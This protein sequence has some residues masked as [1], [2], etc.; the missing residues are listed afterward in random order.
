MTGGEKGIVSTDAELRVTRLVGFEVVD[1]RDGDRGIALAVI[2]GDGLSVRRSVSVRRSDR[3]H[4]Q[5]GQ[6][7]TVP[8]TVDVYSQ[9]SGTLEGARFPLRRT[10]TR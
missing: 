6:S 9:P 4:R 1:E 3:Q 8:V 10:A 5:S 7:V 2:G